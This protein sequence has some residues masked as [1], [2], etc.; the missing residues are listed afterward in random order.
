MLLTLSSGSLRNSLGRNGKGGLSV[1][2]MP[3]FVIKTLQ[4]HGLN[5]SASTLAGW[6]LEDLDKLRDRADKAAC[7]CLVLVEET[8]LP[9]GH[10]DED[11][12]QLAVNRVKRL[13]V[14]AHRLGCSAVAVRCEAP[15]T[16]EAFDAVSDEIRVLMP[17]IERME[18]NILLAPCDGL[19]RTS[20]QLATLIKRIGGFR[21]GS[22]PS[23]GAAAEHGDGDPTE[24]LRKLAPYAGAIHATVEGFNKKGVHK[25]YDL[26]SCVK[27]IRSV[28]FLNTLAIDYTGEDDPIPNIEMARDIMQKAIDS[29]TA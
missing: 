19:T 2:D 1:L 11:K 21:I 26:A 22:L 4:L 15:D 13:A 29:E 20:V 24:G 8:P 25:S 9:F 3:A 17:Q 16:P 6:S 10:A 14:A 23:F 18:L 12:S 28:G 27:A 7:P 5:L